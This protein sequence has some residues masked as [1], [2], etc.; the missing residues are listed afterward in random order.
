M[1]TQ[2]LSGIGMG[3]SSGISVEMI[4]SPIILAGQFDTFSANIK[5]FKEPLKRSIQKVIAPSIRKNFASEGRPSWDPLTDKTIANRAYEGYGSGPILQR[6]GALMKVAG[7]FNIWTINGPAGEAYIADLPSRVWYGKI[8]QGG[9]GLDA[10]DSGSIVARPWAMIQPEDGP[11]IEEVFL[12][13]LDERMG[14]D[15]GA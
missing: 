2:M 12:D 10:F 11:E 8:H 15:L 13:W 5:S 3:N 14:R 9:I 7:Q 1:A 4:P 6:S